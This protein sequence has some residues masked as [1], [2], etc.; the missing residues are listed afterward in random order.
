MPNSAHNADDSLADRLRDWH[1]GEPAEL[2][3]PPMDPVAAAAWLAPA[4]VDDAQNAELR[5]RADALADGGDWSRLDE[6]TVREHLATALEQGRLLA[7][8][9]AR[10]ELLRLVPPMVAAPPPPPPAASSPRAAPTAAPPPPDGTFDVELDVAAMVAVLQQAAEDGVPFCEECA[11]RA[12][13]AE[14]A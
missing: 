4:V 8:T 11:R 12:A 7:G 13:E 9:T 5:L 3:V 2:E 6:F 14:A 10:P 1:E